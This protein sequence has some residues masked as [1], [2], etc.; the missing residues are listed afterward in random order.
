METVPHSAHPS[1][2]SA[3]SFTA[4]S[5]TSTPSL[6]NATSHP[7][8]WIFDKDYDEG[9]ANTLVV[10]SQYRSAEP[11]ASGYKNAVVVVWLDHI[12]ASR[13]VLLVGAL[14]VCAHI[15]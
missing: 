10:L 6:T 15:T 13:C 8:S 2:L 7:L 9:T 11:S 1:A 14:S 5:S 4:L 12:C 3:W